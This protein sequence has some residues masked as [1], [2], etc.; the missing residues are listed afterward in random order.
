MRIKSL[1]EIKAFS[2]EGWT[3]YETCRCKRTDDKNV[4]TGKLYKNDSLELELKQCWLCNDEMYGTGL[5][6]QYISSEC[7]RLNQVKAMNKEE[8]DK[9]KE[10]KKHKTEEQLNKYK[11]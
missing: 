10:L 6:T 9:K 3:H 11:G 7:K 8:A 2:M 4:R 1:N 5:Y